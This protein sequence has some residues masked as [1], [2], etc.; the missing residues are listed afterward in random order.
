MRTL[1]LVIVAALLVSACAPLPPPRP[2]RPLTPLE[3]CQQ[4]VAEKR[5]ECNR[6]VIWALLGP[7]GIGI[8]EM[9]C[10]GDADRIERR[11]VPGS[12]ASDSP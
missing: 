12:F 7:L 9:I 3:E 2:P 10:R 1:A 8:C 6:C 5:Y 11:C 4:A